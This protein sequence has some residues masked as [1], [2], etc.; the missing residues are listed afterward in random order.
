MRI[1]DRTVGAPAAAGYAAN[2]QVD[3]DLPRVAVYDS[4][5]IRVNG[6]LTNTGYAGAPTKF[7]ETPM[8][9]VQSLQ[10]IATGSLQDTIKSI[11][12][13]WA[14]RQTQFLEGTAPF[15]SD[16]GTTNAAFAFECGARLYFRNMRSVN[17]LATLLDARRL[18]G[19]TL[20]TIWRDQT[21]LVT[22]GSGGSSALS[23]TQLTAIAREYYDM[24]A[25]AANAKFAYLKEQQRSFAIAGS[26]QEYLISNLPVGNRYRRICFKGT[27]GSTT[28]ADNS[29]A[30]FNLAASQ[31]VKIRDGSTFPLNVGYFAQRAEDKQLYRVEAMPAGYCVWE[32]VKLGTDAEMY[33]ARAKRQLEALVDVNFTGG[34][35]NTL[36]L[37]TVEYVTR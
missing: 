12:L 37:T 24:P 27:V 16:V 1:V 31:N 6:T 23:A 8:N 20:R 9:I 26:Q 36:Q 18:S 29:D 4:L 2:A 15:T 25:A 3:Q 13:P 19:L 5:W 30:L 17:P 10:V 32:P 28:F 14:Y 7:A 21:S 35:T 33:D 22:G 11:D 34:Q